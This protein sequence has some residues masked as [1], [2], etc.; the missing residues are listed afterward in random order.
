M[1][2]FVAVFVHDHTWLCQ[3]FHSVRECVPVQQMKA[4][5]GVLVLAPL[6]G[7][8]EPET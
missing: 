3:C 1:L 4:G 6:I 2:T 5:R 7:S 8:I